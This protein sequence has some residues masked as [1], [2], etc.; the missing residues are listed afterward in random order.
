MATMLGEYVQ[1]MS[2]HNL[3]TNKST[4]FL[5]F[6]RGRVHFFGVKNK[7][8]MTFRGWGVNTR[9]VSRLL[10]TGHLLQALG[11]QVTLWGGGVGIT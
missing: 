7:V 9:D 6:F 10:L 2:H 3:T 11:R 1:C 4:I 5:N 8:K